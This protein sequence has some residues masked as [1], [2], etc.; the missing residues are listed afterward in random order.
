MED[1]LCLLPGMYWQGATQHKVTSWVSFCGYE[2]LSA[3]QNHTY[4]RGMETGRRDI[5]FV[6]RA[7]AAPFDATASYSRAIA[8][9]GR[10]GQPHLPASPRDGRPEPPTIRS[11]FEIVP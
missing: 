6:W 1:V 2:V 5:R 9:I 8:G 4:D 11:Q 7:S 3:I 10:P